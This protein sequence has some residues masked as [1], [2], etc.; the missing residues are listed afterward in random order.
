VELGDVLAGH[1]EGRR[2]DDDIVVYKAVGIGLQDI[3]L[4]GVV[5]EK[6]LASRAA[7]RSR[8]S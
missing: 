5:W 8:L 3:V 1:V 4:A 6:Y 7:G 2:H